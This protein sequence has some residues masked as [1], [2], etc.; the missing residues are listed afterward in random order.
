MQSKTGRDSLSEVLI[1]HTGTQLPEYFQYL[2][3][4]ELNSRNLVWENGYSSTFAS[5]PNHVFILTTA[6]HNRT[7][8]WP[9]HAADYRPYNQMLFFPLYQLL[10][11]FFTELW[12]QETPKT[13]CTKE[14][15]STTRNRLQVVGEDNRHLGKEQGKV[16]G[17]ANHFW[18]SCLPV[19][20]YPALL[21]MLTL[22]RALKS[23][24]HFEFLSC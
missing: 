24:L 8:L 11:C 12:H 1:L 20:P 15:N 23:H 3:G 16:R 19:P 18:H 4:M 21:H 5:R 13:T 9:H 6:E 14:D 22:S 2:H 10:H 7:L 17:Q